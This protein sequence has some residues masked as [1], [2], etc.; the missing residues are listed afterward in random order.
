MPSISVSISQNCNGA[1]GEFQVSVGA[2]SVQNIWVTFVG[3]NPAN[4]FISAQINGV[5]GA[6]FT[7]SNLP[8]DT[9]TIR[10]HGSIDGQSAAFS[11]TIACSAPPTGNKAWRNLEQY[12]LDNNQPTGRTKANVPTDPDYVAPVPDSTC[13]G[14]DPDWEPVYWTTG[15][16]TRGCFKYEMKYVGSGA[17]QPNRPSTELENSLYEVVVGSNGQNCLLQ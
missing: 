12:Y 15:I 11:R 10:A 5:S 9:Y 4:N 7:Q 3:S 8:N 2:V 1:T 17:A 6:N 13:G 16:Q 14:G